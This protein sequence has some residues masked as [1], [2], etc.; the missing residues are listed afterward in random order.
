MFTA[1]DTV[2]GTASI[3]LP[4]TITTTEPVPLQITTSLAPLNINGF[5]NQIL[6]ATGGLPPYFWSVSA[7]SLPP[8]I[9]LQSNYNLYGIATASGTYNFT[10]RPR[11]MPILQ[12]HNLTLLQWETS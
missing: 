11:I 12:R 6:T 10:C 1:T 4:L 8:G 3:T 2:G 7:G 5:Y 9:S